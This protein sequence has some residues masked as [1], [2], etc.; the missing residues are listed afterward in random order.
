MRLGDIRTSLAAWLATVLASVSLLPLVDGADWLVQGALL[1]LTQTGVGVLLRHSRLSSALVA[2]AQLATGVVLLTLVS[3][4]EYALAGLVP[5]PAVLERFGQLLTA[6]GEDIGRYTTPAPATE[7][8][9]LLIWAGVLL[10]GLLVDLL[11]VPLRNAAAAGLPLLA[12]YSVAAGV[13]QDAAGWGYFAAAGLGYLVLLLSEGRERLSHWGLFYGGAGGGRW[14]SPRDMAMSAGPRARAGRRIGALALGAAL[15]TPLLLPGLGGGLLDVDNDGRSGLGE[16]GT[17]SVDPVVALKDQLNQPE[18]VRLLTYTTDGDPQEMYLRLMALDQ[19]NGSEWASSDWHEDEVPPAPWTV[20]GL[21]RDIASTRAVTEVRASD[22][23]AQP[24]LPVPYPATSIA[25]EGD[26]SFDR[27]SQTLVSDEAALSSRGLGYRV[28][29]LT[30]EPTAGQLAGAPEPPE[31]FREYYTRVPD[32]LPDEVAATAAEITGDAANDHERAVALQ[33]WFTQSGGFRYDTRVDSGTG[34]EAIVNFLERREGFCVH[35]A[36]TMAAMA[37]SLDIPAQVAVG[38]TPG[39][40]NAAGAYEVGAHNAH[41][42][43]ELYFEGVG[44]VRFEPTPGQGN[45]PEYSRPLPPEQEEETGEPDPTERPEPT[46]PTPDPSSA[47]PDRCDPALDGACGEEPRTPEDDGDEAGFPLWPTLGI[48]GGVLLLALLVTGPLLWRTRVRA[49]RLAPGAGPLD[50]WRELTDSAWDYG[51]EPHPS[52]TPRQAAERI[53]RVARLDAEAAAA[54]RELATAVEAELFA[55]PSDASGEPASR[56]GWERPLALV[57]AGLGTGLPRH[58]RLR[59]L[60]LPRSA[61]RVIPR[62]A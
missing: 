2:L 8:I 51:I 28:D 31:D 10:V 61:S 24:S 62:R 15:L 43:P 40:R 48:G 60:L 41:A 30:V 29:H 52:E 20:T 55:P 39:T 34:T 4:R 57:R 49:R 9:R 36:F 56:S 37:R 21:G 19:F 59:A 45:T 16:D 14:M 50:A 18:N 5:T 12:L 26:W 53:V 3:A 22:V 17:I 23:Y 27:G 7:G 33:E 6:G 1:L 46:E 25:A 11:A 13:G 38:F 42:W 58:S 35:F 47:D 44:W 32:N 54:V